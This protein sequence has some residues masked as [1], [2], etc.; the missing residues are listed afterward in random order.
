MV[1][2]HHFCADAGLSR[3]SPVPVEHVM[4]F[5]MYLAYKQSSVRSMRVYLAAISFSERAVGSPDPTADFRVRRMVAGFTRRH[6]PR[7]DSRKPITVCILV[8]L[9]GQFSMLCF[10]DYEATLFRAAAVTLFFGAFRPGE[11]L[12]Q[13][14]V[15]FDRALAHE[16]CRHMGE[17]VLLWLRV[18]KTDPLGRGTM[19]RLRSSP[20]RSLCPVASLQLYL[21]LAPSGPGPLFRH[22][23]GTPLTLSQFRTVF[24]RAVGCMGLDSRDYGLHSFR[25]GAATA[26]DQL[27]LPQEIIQRLGRWRSGA[28]R[29][30]VR[31]P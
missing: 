7:E 20:D 5:L 15:Q 14:T 11:V 2:F 31:K 30:Y 16:D 28:F 21:F 17:H 12:A 4:Q 19:V 10:D 8:G 27:G 6:P 25:I 22:Q 9:L 23:D 18:S 3:V 1:E 29:Y 26:A 13:S 24:H